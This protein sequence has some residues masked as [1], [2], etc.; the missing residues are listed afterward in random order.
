MRIILFSS[1]CAII[2]LVAVAL[3]VY[4]TMSRR[5]YLFTFLIGLPV[6]MGAALYLIDQ[7]PTITSSSDEFLM[8]RGTQIYA[9]LPDNTGFSEVEIE[10]GDS[11]EGILREYFESF[12]SPL[13]SHAATFVEAADAHNLDY[14]LV[15]AISRQESNGCK[16]IPPGS[17]NCWGW[18]I[19]KRGTLHFESFDQGIWTVTEGLRE[20]Y[21]D[22]G[23]TTPEEIMRRYSPYS[24]GTWDAAVE[25]FMNEMQ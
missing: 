22:D 15:A 11:R 21:V 1:K 10:A 12:G 14:R 8:P 16:Y 17:Y 19:H 2:S 9:A 6:M 23:L 5:L 20:K 4:F 24:P 7:E 13:A 18:G 3:F 25:Q